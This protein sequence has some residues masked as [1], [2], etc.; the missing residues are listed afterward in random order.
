MTAE[1]H[2]G[3]R[4]EERAEREPATRPVRRGGEG[5]EE[6]RSAAA[7]D[8]RAERRATVLVVEDEPELRGLVAQWLETKGYA[9]VS[10]ADG[11]EAIEFLQAGLEP[12]VILLDLTMPRMDGWTFLDWLRAQPE[13]EDRPVVIASAYAEDAP[14]DTA[15]RTLA[16]P[17]RPEVLERV[18]AQLSADA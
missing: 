18:L 13:H 11:V 7:R 17:F 4:T 1:T 15:G 6:E 2:E 8:P 10:A 12:D 3:T 9:S 14:H 16:K 5:E